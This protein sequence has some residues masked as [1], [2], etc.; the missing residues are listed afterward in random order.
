V[1][2]Q[3]VLIA[4]TDSHTLDVL[5]KVLSDHIPHAVIDTCASVNQLIHKLEGASYDTIAVS[6][7]L[8]HTYRYLKGKHTLKES[9]P[10]IVTVSQRD[11]PTAQAAWSGNAF[12]LIV[13]PI[14]SH[15]AVQ[16][17]KLALWHSRL[18]QL[19]DS[20]E[21]PVNRFGEHMAAFPHACETEEQFVNKLFAFNLS[22]QAV[23]SSLRLLPNTDDERSRFDVTALVEQL[24]RKRALD[25]LLTMH[26]TGPTH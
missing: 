8:L 26:K 3:T 19:M 25:R 18:L 4:E 5:P 10:L 23:H 24:I 21:C 11:F 20:Q 14:V 7:T 12:D 13:K 16:T 2:A 22:F 9:L 17:I 15:D 1:L 6:A